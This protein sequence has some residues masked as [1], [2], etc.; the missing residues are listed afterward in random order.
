M[1]NRDLSIKRYDWKLRIFYAVTCYHTNEI[2]KS[3]NDIRCPKNI[4]E[5]IKGNLNKCDMDTGFTYSNK[6]LRMSII[7][8]G[9]TSSPVEFINSFEHEI[10]HLVDDIAH[11]CGLEI[12]GED[13]AYLTGDI[14]SALWDDI[15]NFICCKCHE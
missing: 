6:D 5:R 12:A 2:L 7:V 13:V 14:N 10:R 4:I 15:H 3:L 9:I 11:T 1:K 8:I